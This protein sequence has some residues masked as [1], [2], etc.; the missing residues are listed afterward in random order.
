MLCGIFYQGGNK[1][2]EN[3]TSIKGEL[4]MSRFTIEKSK[5]TGVYLLF[6]LVFLFLMVLTTSCSRQPRPEFGFEVGRYD[7]RSVKRTLQKMTLEEKV[8]QMVACRF[9]GIFLH[10]DS[11]ELKA[12]ENLIRKH[13]VGGF[14]LFGGEAYETA[15][16][17]NYLQS[18]SKHPLL[19]ASDLE[20]GTGNQVTG[21]TLFPPLMSLGASGSE[22]LAFEMGRITAI[23]GRA[24]GIHMTYAPVVDVNVNPDNPIINTRSIG[25]DPELVSRI[26]AAFI[27]GVQQHGMIAT[28]KH[29]PGH[30]DTS[31]DSHSLLPTINVDLD[32]LERVELLPF[33]RAVEAGVRAIMTAHLS[34][35]ALDPEPG[36]PATLSPSIITEVLR[37]KIGFRGLIVTDALEMQAITNSYSTEEAAV[38][39]VL[40]GVD[41]LLLPLDTE[42][43]IAA[44]VDSVR[45][46]RIPVQR[47]DE[48][49]Y[50]ILEV[51]HF[52]GLNQNRYVSIENLNSIIGSKKSNEIAQQAFEKS[53][54]LVRNEASILPI[55]KTDKSITV[56]SLSS[57]KG[58]Y[59]AGRQFV[60]EVKKRQPLAREFYADGDTG[61]ETLDNA[62]AHAAR[63]DLVVIALFS[64]LSAGKGT[65]DLEPKHIDLI[66]KLLSLDKKPAVVV[67]S[68][69]S[70]YFLKH[71][72]GVDG[73]LAIYRNTPQTQVIA[74]RAVF[75]EMDVQGRLPVSI[76]GCYPFGYGLEL[77]AIKQ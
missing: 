45:S 60:S 21:A 19:I 59:Y 10:K 22:E 76:P 18:R 26:A 4:R 70:P 17:I 20:R 56:L 35:P 36:L 67:V 54:T 16:L 9:S 14:I 2:F 53:A 15:H 61:Q 46:G 34:V 51:K 57:D 6:L 68:F 29:F 37:K 74:A 23:E 52:L 48:S 43:A 55:P 31:E 44:V 7:L 11:D 40:A 27:R 66:L 47:L 63:S 64:R 24:L 62:L 42:R 49:V 38:L 3:I 8:G 65:T 75:G 39:S 71:F 69:G 58:D 25:E 30:G 13:H 1:L 5:P 73:Y 28:A 32:R 50:R 12:M 33:R 41:I 77:K 72:P